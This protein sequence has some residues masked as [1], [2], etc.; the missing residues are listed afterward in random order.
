MLKKKKRKI[1]KSAATGIIGLALIGSGIGVGYG[2][3]GRKE[4]EKIEKS[5]IYVKTL[6]ELVGNLYYPESVEVLIGRN[7]YGDR[8]NILKVTAT[9]G[10]EKFEFV[11]YEENTCYFEKLV[12]YFNW[13]KLTRNPFGLIDPLYSKSSG[14]P[15]D[16]KNIIKLRVERDSNNNPVYVIDGDDIIFYHKDRLY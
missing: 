14:Y 9:S 4:G 10:D 3:F 13:L 8:V 12:N 15:R 2:I 6:D 16:S 11:I 1:L 5:H 7:P